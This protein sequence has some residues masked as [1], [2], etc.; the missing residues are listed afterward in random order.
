MYPVAMQVSMT[1]SVAATP[2]KM[3]TPSIERSH[4]QATLNK[5]SLFPTSMVNS[6]R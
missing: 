6:S 4:L 1:T 3:T 2:S 5:S